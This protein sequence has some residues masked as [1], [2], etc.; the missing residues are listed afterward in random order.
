VKNAAGYYA[1]DNMD[2]ADLFIG[3]EGTLAITS[4]I[5]LGLRRKPKFIYGV[6]VF[7]G[8]EEDAL[9]YVLLVRG[10]R[11]RRLPV[12]PVA[13][14]YFDPGA[15]S[16]IGR[17]CEEHEAFRHIPRA[18][19]AAAAAV[20]VELHDNA[21]G[22]LDDAL[23]ALQDLITECRGD[24][25]TTWIATNEKELDALVGFRHSLPEAVN[26]R[27]AS[28]KKDYPGITKLGADMSVPDER[29]RDMYDTY[30]RGIERERLESVIFGHIGANHLHVNVIPKTAE[31]YERGK[32][33]YQKWAKTAVAF[34]GSI[35]AEHGI[36]KLK[37]ALLRE[38]YG[39]KGVQEM[40][41]V[42]ELFDPKY[43]LGRGNLFPYCGA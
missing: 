4:A 12:K 38:M 3:S 32:A 7:F 13:I 5:E 9:D 29:L 15:L 34:G 24:E 22:T 40:R 26:M 10:D 37:V 23:A 1:M 33:L 28:I 2:L 6:T 17:I 39:T 21:Q 31:E 36:G 27:I 43:V 11:A 35:S 30:R 14:E 25:N 8:K 41:A 18:P 19:Q 16:F 42:K 20:Y